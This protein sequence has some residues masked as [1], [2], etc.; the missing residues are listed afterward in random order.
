MRPRRTIDAMPRS[1]IARAQVH[2]AGHLDHASAVARHGA[3]VAGR[4][5]IALGQIVLWLGLVVLSLT[6]IGAVVSRAAPRSAEL[7]RLREHQQRFQEIEDQRR[8][9]EANLRA[10]ELATPPQLELDAVLRA[11][12]IQR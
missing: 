8:A 10:I 4:H 5:A 6:A 11:Y 3:R 2:G 7:E 12:P 1:P 9:L